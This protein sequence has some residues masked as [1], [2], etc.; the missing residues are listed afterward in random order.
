MNNYKKHFKIKIDHKR[1]LQSHTIQQINSTSYPYSQIKNTLKNRNIIL[2]NI[3]I[4]DLLL[5]HPLIF[6]TLLLNDTQSNSNSSP[7]TT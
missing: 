2:N 4:K 3:I 5:H 6:Q 1:Q 7:K